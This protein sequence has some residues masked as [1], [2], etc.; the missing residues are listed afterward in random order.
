MS[1]QLVN[2]AS[3]ALAVVGI[4][5]AIL[6]VLLGALVLVILV[7]SNRAEPDGRG[8]RPFSV[9]VF[10]MS[11]LTLWIAYVGSIAVVTSLTAP[12]ERHAFPLTNAVAKG[13]TVG[14]IITAL[15]G[16]VL[17]YH[18]RLGR[19]IAS[20]DERI[21]GPNRRV[22]HTYVAAVAFVATVVAV[23]ALGIIIYL[24]FVLAGPGVYGTGSPQ[25]DVVRSL[26]DAAYVFVGAAIIGWLHL[27]MGPAPLLPGFLRRQAGRPA[28]PQAGEVG[29]P[30]T[31]G[32][33]P[34]A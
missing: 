7:V 3:S 30:A 31:G 24:M 22:L 5:A 29:T 8:L 25:A 21:D 9:Y 20:G 23:V 12:I 27:R 11:F 13:C 4:G 18:L 16:A 28:P 14:A 34:S 6:L 1:A 15:A 19:R 10:A 2:P 17:W 33:P 32:L 26:V